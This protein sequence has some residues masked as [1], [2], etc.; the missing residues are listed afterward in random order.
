[1][2]AF[3]V[4]LCFVCASTVNKPK[5]ALLFFSSNAPQNNALRSWYGQASSMHENITLLHIERA[6]I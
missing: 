5:T 1:M 6:F 4:L 3:D 2:L